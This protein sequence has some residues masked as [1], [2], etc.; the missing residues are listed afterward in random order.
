MEERFILKPVGRVKAEKD[1]FWIMIDEPFRGALAKLGMFSHAL[2]LWWAHEHDNE[3][4]RNRTDTALPYA[5][6]INAGVFACR[7]EYRPNPVAVTVCRILSV[8]ESGGRVAVSWI[9]AFDGSPVLNLKA[10]FPVSDRVRD[11]RV[12]SWAAG[13]PEWYEDAYKLEEIFAKLFSD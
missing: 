1:E 2:V 12:P 9:D 6:N 3:G 5:D 7:S 8:D 4:D 13:W 10:Y 11:V